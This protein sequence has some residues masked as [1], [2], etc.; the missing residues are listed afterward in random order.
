[1]RRPSLRPARA[2]PLRLVEGLLR[3]CER[4]RLIRMKRKPSRI[5][6]GIEPKVLMAY[7]RWV[8][9]H[10]DELVKNHAGKFIAVYRNKLVA[11][12]N[13]YK[14]VYAVAAKQGIEEPPLTMQVPGMEDLEAIL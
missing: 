3:D 7:D 9:K 1:M 4:G 6:D 14:E 12:G 13:S 10:F 2:F 8:A 11:V 5:A